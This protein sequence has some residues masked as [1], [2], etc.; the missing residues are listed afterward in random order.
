MIAPL[1]PYSIKGAIWYQGESNAGKAWEYRT[2]FPTMIKGWRSAWRQ[3]DFPFLFVQLAPFSRTTTVPGDNNWAELR[4]AQLHTSQTLSATGMA[5]I[6]DLGETSD[7]HPRRK[8]AVGA[9]L[10]VAA[11]NIGYGESI[12]PSGP[13]FKDMSVDGNKAVLTFKHIGK[14]LE[15]QGGLPLGFTVA[16]EDRKFYNALAEIRGDNVMVWSD[17]V[18]KPVAVRFGWAMYPSVD[19]WNKDGLPA[20]PF[21]T[22]DFPLTTQPKK[23]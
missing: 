19:L 16:G 9:R 2:L 5:V 1:I 23:P 11:R 6:T 21:R 4:D 10:A 14:G 12:E 8:A 17:K 18:H 3:G 15:A 7:I 22:D 13:I 20:S